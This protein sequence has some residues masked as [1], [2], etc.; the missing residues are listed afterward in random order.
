MDQEDVLYVYSGILFILKKKEIL[1]YK[2]P[3]EEHEA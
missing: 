2:A 3:W 1:T